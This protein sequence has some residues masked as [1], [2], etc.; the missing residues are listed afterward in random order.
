VSHAELALVASVAKLLS[1][2]LGTEAT[3]AA[4]AET[5]RRGLPATAVSVWFREPG[6][7]AFRVAQ[8]PPTPDPPAHLR[9][10]A[11]LPPRPD[12]RRFV[13]EHEGTRLGVL[14]A[15][16]GLIRASTSDPRGAIRSGV[17]TVT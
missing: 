9:S 14:E 15:R 1:E 7:T 5:L 3:L 13:L 2:G 12:W 11:A 8:A 17:D 4:V 10:L 16:T 6:T